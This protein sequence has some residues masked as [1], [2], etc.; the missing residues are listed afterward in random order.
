MK[1][2]FC[3]L[4]YCVA[5]MLSACT[6]APSDTQMAE[7][8][9]TIIRYK[10]NADAVAQYNLARMYYD[11]GDF[12]QARWYRLAGDQGD[13]EAL[14]NLGLMYYEG[15][16][17]GMNYPMA[18]RL[19]RDVAEKARFDNGKRAVRAL[20]MLGNSYS[21][22]EGVDRDYVEAYKWYLLAEAQGHA[23]APSQMQALELFMTAN[24]IADARRRALAFAGGN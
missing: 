9:N 23:D 6:V 7:N 22:G 10:E 20:D 16:G 3:Q 13:L 1:Q 4:T 21:K 15:Q 12:V 17:V 24:Q 19:F 18:N 11:E 14:Y 2:K 5:L 8:G